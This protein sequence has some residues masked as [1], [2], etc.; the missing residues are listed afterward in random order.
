MPQIKITDT[1]LDSA[2]RV[3]IAG[4]EAEIVQQTQGSLTVE[5]PDDPGPGPWTI[6]VTTPRRDD[7]LLNYDPE[8]GESETPTDEG[9]DP[10]A[11]ISKAINDAATKIA[12]AIRGQ[13]PP[14]DAPA[15]DQ[16]RASVK[17]K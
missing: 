13:Q 3:M 8:K 17:R 15:G 6:V 7:D 2:T 11:K 1:D 5:V 10:V 16:P 9:G 12:D 14:S 4:K